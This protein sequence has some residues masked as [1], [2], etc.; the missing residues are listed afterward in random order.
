MALFW[1]FFDARA[2]KKDVKTFGNVIHIPIC[3]ADDSDLTPVL[4][5]LPPPE[6]HLRIG[7]VN[8]MYNGLADLWSESGRWLKSCN[9]RKTEYHGGSF[10]GNDSRKLL[11]NVQCLEDMCPD[12]CKNYFDAFKCFDAVVSTYYGDKLSPDFKQKIEAFSKSYL[13]LNINVTPNIHAVM[14]HV[15][16]FCELTGRGLAPWSQQTGESL[17]HDFKQIW[18]KFQFKDFEH[19]LYGEHLLRAVSMHSSQHL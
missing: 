11:R 6:L 16:E 15:V 9:A 7:S 17:H 8:T 2:D 13:N 4:A 3:N 10:A 14:H 12:S 19:P 5:L 1:H 18:E